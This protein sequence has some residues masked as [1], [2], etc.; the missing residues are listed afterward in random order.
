MG[1]CG[2]LQQRKLPKWISAPPCLEG[3][4]CYH[5]F[6][7]NS[8]NNFKTETKFLNTK[9]QDWIYGYVES[10]L[11]YEYS[12]MSVEPELGLIPQSYVRKVVKDVDE[13]CIRTKEIIRDICNRRKRLW[14]TG[15]YD[16]NN[17]R[18]A[19]KRALSQTLDDNIGELLQLLRTRIHCHN[20]LGSY[21]LQE[22]RDAIVD[23]VNQI[24]KGHLQ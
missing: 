14:L 22:N 20:K 12:P 4:R 17:V 9:Y 21:S 23:K 2:L 19:E 11:F 18:G 15:K 8:G 1:N 16:P 13:V 24:S 7:A 6:T 5:T 3:R 10:N